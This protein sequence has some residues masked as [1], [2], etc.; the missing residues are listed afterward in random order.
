MSE[1][2]TPADIANFLISRAIGEEIE[3][4]RNLNKVNAEANANADAARRFE[5][6]SGP[7]CPSPNPYLQNQSSFSHQIQTAAQKHR[8]YKQIRDFVVKH[9]TQ[10]VN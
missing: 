7:C 6:E 5:I 10:Y 8:D 9:F 4:E 1:E 3:A 2:L